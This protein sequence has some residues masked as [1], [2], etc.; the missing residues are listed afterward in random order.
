MNEISGEQIQKA[1]AVIR[2]GGLVASPTETCYGLIV[3]PF[4]EHALRKLFRVKQRPEI[5]P[6]LVLI[7]NRSQLEML[8]SS[9]PENAVKLMDHF[10]P[11]PLT[12]IFPARPD[13]SSIL[14][15]NTSTVGVRISPNPF[16]TAL[17]KACGIPLTATSANKSGNNA[18]VSAGEVR[19]IFGNDV[20]LILDGGKT[21]GR[22]GSTLIGFKGD[23]ITCIRE[24][25]IPFQDILNAV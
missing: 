24:G 10:W 9:I 20:D 22:L 12:M 13:L 21:P 25:R 4:N 6:V 5:K 14:T 17:L 2:N 15:G 1:A 11:G 8:V 16:A 19:A 7:S 3:D 23:Q 18:A